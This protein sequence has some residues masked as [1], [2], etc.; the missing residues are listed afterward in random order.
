[1]IART[2][3]AKLSTVITSPITTRFVV[4]RALDGREAIVPNEKMITDTVINHSYTDKQVRI[5]IQ[6]QV[7]YKSDLERALEV[8]KRVAADHPRV[9]S[10]PA[11]PPQIL[12]F[13][14][15]GVEL[16]LGL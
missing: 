14:D 5:T 3:P 4:V 13:G 1:M 10:E 6:V 2:S 9:L 16:E 11:A 8:L 7:S 15:N 12:K